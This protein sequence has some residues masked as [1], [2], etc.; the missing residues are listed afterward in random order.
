[1][2]VIRD[3][4]NLENNKDGF[5]F[6]FVLYAYRDEKMGSFTLPFA[7]LNEAVAERDFQTALRDERT[8]V[9]KYPGDFVLYEIGRFDQDK[10]FIEGHLVPKYVIRG[11]ELI[12]KVNKL[13]A[14]AALSTEVK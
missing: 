10:G 5:N 9:S 7:C 13:A 2:T 11:S 3:P 12:D 8:N 14:S 4:F 6:R 1:M